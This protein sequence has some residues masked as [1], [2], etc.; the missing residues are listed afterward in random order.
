MSEFAYTT[1]LKQLNNRL[2]Y[3]DINLGLDLT[4]DYMHLIDQL[5]VLDQYLYFNDKLVVINLGHRDLSGI[6][7]LTVEEWNKEHNEKELKRRLEKQIRKALYIK[8]I[9]E[10][11]FIIT[12]FNIDS[13]N[14][15]EENINEIETDLDLFEDISEE[16]KETEV[17]QESDTFEDTEEYTP[18]SYE[19]SIQDF[20]E[21]ETSSA[22][23]STSFQLQNDEEY[24]EEDNEEDDQPLLGDMYND[25]LEANKIMEEEDEYDEYSD[26]YA[27]FDDEDETES[28]VE[29]NYE[30]ES[31]NCSDKEDYAQ[32]FSNDIGT[33]YKRE[34]KAADRV[35]DK[36]TDLVNQGLNSLLKKLAGK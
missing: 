10:T 24:E 4:V 27:I 15:I 35:V 6:E 7:S 5:N 13:L 1:Y 14:I 20:T 12:P 21:D 36:T 33:N 23:P 19:P 9:E 2:E 16:L 34:E 3:R 30:E 22:S 29:P 32:E 8:P 31:Y 17:K 11:D 28:E 26:E 25:L 18:L